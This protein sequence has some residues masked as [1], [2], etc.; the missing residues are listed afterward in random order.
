MHLEI[1][2][3]GGGGDGAGGGGGGWKRILLFFIMIDMVTII[4]MSNLEVKCYYR[5]QFGYSEALR[6]AEK[7]NSWNCVQ[8]EYGCFSEWLT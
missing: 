7:T 8:T 3:G 6:N 1:M 4:Q 5:G 2:G